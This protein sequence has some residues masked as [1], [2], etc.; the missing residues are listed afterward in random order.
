MDILLLDERDVAMVVLA[1]GHLA[2]E[3]EVAFDL[4]HTQTVGQQL[5]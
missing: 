3:G 2:V 5:E 1:L 4:A